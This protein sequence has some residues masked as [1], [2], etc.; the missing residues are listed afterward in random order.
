M[1][2]KNIIVINGRKLEFKDGETILDVAKKNGI[3]IP[4]LCHLSRTPPINKCKLCVVEL[5]GVND[6]VY[7]CSTYA[8]NN[9][10]IKTKTSA[11]IKQIKNRL[12]SFFS[13]GNHNCSIRN[14]NGC[15]WTKFQL[16]VQ[17]YDKSSK[18][19]PVWGNCKLQD[20]GYE[21]NIFEEMNFKEKESNFPLEDINPFIVR[22]FSRCILCGRCV[23]ACRNIQ[24]NNAIYFNIKN[25]IPK[26]ITKNDQPLK[27]SECV[28]CGECI[29]VCPVGALVEKNARYNYRPWKTRKVRTTC[30][31]CGVG[32]QIYLHVEDNKIVKVSGVENAMPNKGSLCVKGRFGFDFV[33]SKERLTFPL[34]KEKG[35]FRKASWSEAIKLIANK[36]NDILENTGGD[37][38]GVLTSAR[39]T[40]E[41]NYIA[42]KFTRAVLKTNNIDHCARL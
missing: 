1:N 12:V 16:K 23:S 32:C 3:N 24:V 21:Y 27:N 34:I 26:I 38:I 19:C 30:S 42:N 33:N 2:I 18:L 35:E 6:F 20:F 15:D 41:D 40:N 31:Y 25:D 13:S 9:M 11:I 17:K 5:N 7:A 29:Q 14:H 28:F 22:Y 37:S 10:E 36:F 8:K 4:T 39:M